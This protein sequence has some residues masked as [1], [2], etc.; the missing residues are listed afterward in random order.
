MADARPG[1]PWNRADAGLPRI[2]TRPV[3]QRS[4]PTHPF[5]SSPDAAPTR[6][7]HTPTGYA[8]SGSQIG[9][10]QP[11]GLFSDDEIDHASG[12]YDSIGG[13]VVQ[14]ERQLAGRGE[15]W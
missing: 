9:Q 6:P 14:L 7:G 11:N 1:F 13:K 8:G 2:P 15:R 4:R 12:R 3:A 10:I 5:G